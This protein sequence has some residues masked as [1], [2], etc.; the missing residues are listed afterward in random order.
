M[1]SAILEALTEEPKLFPHVC[2][3]MSSRLL[4]TLAARLPRTPSLVL[5]VGSGSGLLEELLHLQTNG[6][7]NIYGVEV[8]S[9]RSVYLPEDRTLRVPSTTSVHADAI[10][11]ETLIFCYPRE[12]SLI[13][14]YVDEFGS[15]ALAQIVL[16]VNHNDWN[17]LSD[18]LHDC[19]STVELVDSAGLPGY[20]VLVVASAPRGRH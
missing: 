3:G 13:A 18:I 1:A 5:S 9:C 4:E 15:G 19:F 8:P 6:S 16:I 7:I 10:L 14:K 17:G 2:C 20:E 12:P 11:A